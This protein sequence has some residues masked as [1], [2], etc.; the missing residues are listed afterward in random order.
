METLLTRID[1]E[2]DVINERIAYNSNEFD[3]TRKK[4]EKK[5]G[6]ALTE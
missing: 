2:I 5:I 1:S 6:F 4:S 3:G